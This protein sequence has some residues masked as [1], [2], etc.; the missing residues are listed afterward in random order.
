MLWYLSLCALSYN[1][2]CGKGSFFLFHY[3]SRMSDLSQN[4]SHNKWNSGCL[5]TVIMG[6]VFRNTHLLCISVLQGGTEQRHRSS[7]IVDCC[8]LQQSRHV[9]RHNYSGFWLW[10]VGYLYVFTRWLF[11]QRG[12]FTKF[13]L[14]INDCAIVISWQSYWRLHCPWDVINE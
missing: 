4:S 8:I 3:T 5:L 10:D 12:I 11:E 1:V 2:L 7:L 6:L 9:H 13:L 14:R